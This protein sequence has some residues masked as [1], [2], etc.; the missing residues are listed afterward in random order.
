M[1]RHLDGSITALKFHGIDRKSL[2]PDI[3]TADIILTTYNTLTRDFQR[4]GE[5]SLLHGFDWR[6]IVLDEGD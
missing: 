4:K 3:E 6:R 2:A 5:P 1:D